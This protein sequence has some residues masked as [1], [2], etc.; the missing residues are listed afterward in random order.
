MSKIH[1]IR[2]SIEHK[3][4]QWEDMAEA[5]ELQL[6]LGRAEALQ[7]FDEQREK[8]RKLTEAM[9]PRLNALD[10]MSEEARARIQSALE[11]LQVQLAL[12]RAESRDA[13]LE[14]REKLRQAVRSVEE[15]LGETAESGG[16]ETSQKLTEEL[17]TFLRAGDRLLAELEALELQF[18]VHAESARNK[19]TDARQKLTQQIQ[20]FRKQLAEQRA[21]AAERLAQSEAELGE[22]ARHVKEAFGRLLGRRSTT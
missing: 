16:A 8:L 2:Q 7:R 5:L 22:A 15:R 13:Y 9:K 1:Q 10:T 20:S 18:E 14:Q 3:L 4:N 17:Q 19:L 12:G 21:K 11:H 6:T